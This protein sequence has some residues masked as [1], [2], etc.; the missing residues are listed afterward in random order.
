MCVQ[1]LRREDPLEKGIATLL[2]ME[3]LKNSFLENTMDRRTWRATVH[4]VA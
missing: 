3:N 4:R 2:A 1:S